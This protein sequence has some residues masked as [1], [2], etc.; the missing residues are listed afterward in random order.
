[1]L[2]NFV[3][4]YIMDREVWND[5]VYAAA[6]ASN[7]S[8]AA[9]HWTLGWVWCR[10]TCGYGPGPFFGGLLVER[11]VLSMVGL[12]PCAV[13]GTE[14]DEWREDSRLFKQMVGLAS[15]NAGEWSNLLFQHNLIQRQN[16]G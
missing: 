1:M 10:K 2:I 15:S 11:G 9:E 3:E 5:E 12:V 7:F 6:F 4:H 14:I 13:G 16:A 8:I